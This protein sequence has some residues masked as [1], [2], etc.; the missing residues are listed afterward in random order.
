MFL[1]GR[2]NEQLL[3][4]VTPR[5]RENY[6]TNGSKGDTRLPDGI[7]SNQKSKF[8]I[9]REDLEMEYFMNI[10]SIL[11]SLCILYGHLVHLCNWVYFP[12]FWYVVPRN[13][14]QPWV[15]QWWFYESPFLTVMYVH[16][17][18]K[19]TDLPNDLCT[20]NYNWIYRHQMDKKLIFLFYQCFYLNLRS[21]PGMP[22]FSWSTHMYQNGKNIPN[23]YIQ[24]IPN[25]HYVYQIAV[26]Y[27]KWS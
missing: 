1:A 7:F 27:F 25:G 2:K 15:M 20:K 9:L 17:W 19:V 23:D 10:W 16:A 3:R 24:T 14:L 4:N 6:N 8:G 26:K 18:V 13:I 21:K 12:P 5:G 22:D 11:K